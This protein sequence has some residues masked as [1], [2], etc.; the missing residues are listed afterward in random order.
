MKYRTA[1]AM[2]PADLAHAC[3]QFQQWR[4]Q[5]QTRQRLPLKLWE[6]A[7]KLANKYGI[8]KTAKT[9]RLGHSDLKKRC[10]KINVQESVN[11]V[12]FLDVT[13]RSEAILPKIECTIECQRQFNETIR[14]QL[15]GSDWPNLIEICDRL[16]NSDQ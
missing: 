10:L 14:I 4:D 5:H 15:K 6:M 3:R 16:W 1:D 13:P 7:V 8:T 9:L 12:S 2:L 11:T